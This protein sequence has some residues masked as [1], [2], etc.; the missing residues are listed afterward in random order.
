[1]SIPTLIYFENGTMTGKVVGVQA[2][3]QIA[4]AMGV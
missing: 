1:M 2:K 4:A 3:E